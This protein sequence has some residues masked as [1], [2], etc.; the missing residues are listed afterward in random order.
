[1]TILIQHVLAI[2][3][4]IKDSCI[5]VSPI[6]PMTKTDVGFEFIP[7]KETNHFHIN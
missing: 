5:V 7:I 4:E 2:L 6:V 1:M 3:P